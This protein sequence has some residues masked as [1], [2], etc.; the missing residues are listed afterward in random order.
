TD[1]NSTNNSVTATTTYQATLPLLSIND[2]SKNEGNSGTTTFTFTVSLSTPAQA[3]GVTFDIATQDGT[4]KVSG[5]DYVAKS[6][7]GQTI[8]AGDQTY[9]FDVTVNGD[10]LVEPDETFNVNVTN[11]SGAS[12]S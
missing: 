1:T 3:G 2:V 4:A 12:V 6:L 7:A 11:V 8:A 9:T 10:T 5:N